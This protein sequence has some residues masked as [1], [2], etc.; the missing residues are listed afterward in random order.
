[1]NSDPLRLQTVPS[2]RQC[3]TM[4][5]AYSPIAARMIEKESLSFFSDDVSGNAVQAQLVLVFPILP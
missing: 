2:M 5:Q 1:M 3:F 4:R